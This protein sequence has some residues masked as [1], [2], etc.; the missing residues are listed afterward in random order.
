MKTWKRF[1]AYKTGCDKDRLR[2]IHR[3]SCILSFCSSLT[4]AFVK[5]SNERSREK[6]ASP[7]LFTTACR[8]LG[9]TLDNFIFHRSNRFELHATR[10]KPPLVGKQDE[11]VSTHGTQ[12]VCT[13]DSQWQNSVDQISS[14]RL[15]W[16]FTYRVRNLNCEFSFAPRFINSKKD[17]VFMPEIFRDFPS[18]IRNSITQIRESDKWRAKLDK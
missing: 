14:V 4:K 5:R 1:Y 16:D 15:R 18:S 2:V 11:N 13:L 3:N 10:I 9:G 17:V 6:K 12:F 7:L 8:S